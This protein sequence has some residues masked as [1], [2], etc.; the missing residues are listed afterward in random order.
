MPFVFLKFIG[1]RPIVKFDVMSQN[2]IENQI[3]TYPYLFR[4]IFRYGNIILTPIIVIY[5]VPLI[6][7]FNQKPILAVPIIVNLFIIYFLNNHY[8]NLYKI[9]PYKIE[10]DD[11]KN[12][13][14]IGF[15]QK[16]TNTQKLATIILSKVKRSIY[17]EVLD[18][19]SS[20]K[21]DK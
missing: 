14:C 20:R 4:F 21:K 18:K 13:L 9:L 1:A 7:Y 12:N 6:Y 5:S 10:A 8:F 17:D 19:I 2:K 16:L 11:E 3:F 15:Y